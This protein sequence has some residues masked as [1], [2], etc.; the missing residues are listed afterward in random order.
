MRCSD[1]LARALF[2]KLYSHGT[3]RANSVMLDAASLLISGKQSCHQDPFCVPHQIHISMVDGGGTLLSPAQGVRAVAVTLNPA[4]APLPYLSGNVFRV[5]LTAS[6][7][8]AGDITVNASNLPSWPELWCE[9]DRTTEPM[10]PAPP[11]VEYGVSCERCNEFYE[12][13]EKRPGF[14]CYPCRN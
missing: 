2:D 11:P 5:F 14:V 9:E 10:L 12:H 4:P 3:R 13:A 7:G 1:A 8:L 6:F